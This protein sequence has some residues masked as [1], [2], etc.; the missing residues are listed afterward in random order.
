MRDSVVKTTG[1]LFDLGEPKEGHEQAGRRPVV[2]LQT[3]HL[4]PLNTVVVVP[5]TTQLRHAGL[6]EQRTDPGR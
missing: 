1:Q 4:S 6:C 5:L 2:I 3:D